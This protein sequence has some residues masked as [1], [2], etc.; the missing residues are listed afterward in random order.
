MEI[1]VHIPHLREGQVPQWRVLSRGPPQRSADRLHRGQIHLVNYSSINRWT[2]VKSDG[3]DEGPYT[4]HLTLPDDDYVRRR[5]IID[6]GFLPRDL[7]RTPDSGL[8]ERYPNYVINPENPSVRHSNLARDLSSD[9]DLYSTGG[10]RRITTVEDFALIQRVRRIAT[11]YEAEHRQPATLD[12]ATPKGSGF[13]QLQGT[14][15]Q[16][17][18]NMDDDR[19]RQMEMDLRRRQQLTGLGIHPEIVFRQ[20]HIRGDGRCF[21]RAFSQ[22]YFGTQRAWLRVAHDAERMLVR[23]A[24]HRDY[25]GDRTVTNERWIDYTALNA[26]SRRLR[27][28]SLLD[29]ARGNVYGTDALAQVLADVSLASHFMLDG[30]TC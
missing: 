11:E 23:A 15:V 13:A 5:P 9:V 16:R 3:D 27:L 29:Q 18:P 4:A 17:R 20:H 10:T 1:L 24:M 19:I 2:A 14:P 21:L 28:G 6:D 8:P 26:E 30:N 7:E 25:L 22:A 12:P